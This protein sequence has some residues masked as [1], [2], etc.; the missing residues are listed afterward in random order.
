MSLN[1]IWLVPN[2][3]LFDGIGARLVSAAFAVGACRIV[4]KLSKKRKVSV[5]AQ[6][7]CLLN[8]RYLLIIE[9]KLRLNL[10]PTLWFRV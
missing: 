3:H 8:F 2:P 10:S 7:L 6:S 5:M 1:I 4:K 9:Y